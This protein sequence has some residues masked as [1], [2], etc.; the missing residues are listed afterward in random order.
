ML[1]KQ[2]SPRAVVLPKSL[3]QMDSGTLV[4][5]A[6]SGSFAEGTCRGILRYHRQF[7]VSFWHAWHLA[8]SGVGIRRKEVGPWGTGL[9][10]HREW[11]GTSI[12]ST[13]AMENWLMWICF[14]LASD[15]FFLN[16][17]SVE[18]VLW[19]SLKRV[20]GNSLIGNSSNTSCK[21]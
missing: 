14:G 13:V 1:L 9:H 20:G 8:R 12:F 5:A 3:S 21:L 18:A 10:L 17:V 19:E 6:A 15:F 7:V 2:C 11:E 4:A 16:Y